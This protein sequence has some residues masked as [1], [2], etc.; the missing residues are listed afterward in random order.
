MRSMFLIGFFGGVFFLI[1]I[2]TGLYLF[3]QKY[4][5][6]VE[7]TLVYIHG[8][9]DEIIRGKSFLGLIEL[10]F[11]HF[12]A[13]FLS[14]FVISHIFY[15]FR[16]KKLHFYLAGTVF[17]SGFLNFLSPFLVLYNKNLAFLKVFSFSIFFTSVVF[18][19]VYLCFLTFLKIRQKC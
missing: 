12:L 10:H 2:F 14:V 6:S 9:P 17:L 13:I 3:Y 4:G 8:D 1:E 11:P 5:F 15:F 7:K 18:M 16:I 19:A